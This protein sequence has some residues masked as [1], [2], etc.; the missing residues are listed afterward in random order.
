MLDEW[1]VMR[2]PVA[3]LVAL[4][5]IAP[6][7]AANARTGCGRART[8]PVEVET[9]YVTPER[10]ARPRFPGQQVSLRVRV[11]RAVRPG[12]PL[13]PQTEQLPIALASVTAQLFSG[14]RLLDDAGNEA[15]RMG[16]VTLKF[17]LPTS[18]PAGPVA[19]RADARYTTVGSLDC[20]EPYVVETG[21]GADDAVLTVR[22]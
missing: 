15:D 16:W 22:R 7:V 4:A 11:T 21:S 5:V 8:G 20:T 1:S 6:P 13:S 10:D 18:T 2:T 17:N 12:S 19:I 9:L 3:L 14:Q